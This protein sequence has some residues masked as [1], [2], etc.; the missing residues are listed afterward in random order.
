MAMIKSGEPDHVLQRFINSMPIDDRL[1]CME[2]LVK[3]P[4]LVVINTDKRN[5]KH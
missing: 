2:M 4:P 3:T 5:G 1:Y